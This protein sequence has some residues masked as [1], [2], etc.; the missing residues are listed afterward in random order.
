MVGERGVNFSEGQVQRLSIARAVLCKAPLLIMDEA[1]SALDNDTEERVLK[2]L[3]ES[4]GKRI[5]IITTHR[6]SML[7]FC[8]RIY[9]LQ[10]NGAL[11]LRERA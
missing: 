4:D 1:T 6:P 7:K 3:L 5:C 11:K 9:E 10:E 2:A 8:N